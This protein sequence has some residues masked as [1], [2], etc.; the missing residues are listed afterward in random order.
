V[1]QNQSVGLSIAPQNRW[2]DEDGVGHASR[3]SSFLLVKASRTI[4]F[5]SDLKT[6]GGATAGS[7]RGTIADVT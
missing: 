2:E 5:Q 7:A 6:S 3:S 1:P 4:V